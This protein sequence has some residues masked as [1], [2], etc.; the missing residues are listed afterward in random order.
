M[1]VLASIIARA[2]SYNKSPLTSLYIYILLLL[3]LQRT[4]TML[5]LTVEGRIG[6]CVCGGG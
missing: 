1:R 2:N 4:L 3:F 5:G 6:I